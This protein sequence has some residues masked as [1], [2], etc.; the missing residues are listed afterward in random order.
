MRTLVLKTLFALLPLVAACDA[1]APVDAPTPAPGHRAAA[2]SDAPVSVIDTGHWSRTVACS[3]FCVNEYNFWVDLR[4]RND[5]FDKEVGILWTDSGW[6]SIKTSMAHY[7]GPLED[8]WEQ[9]G[10]DVTVGTMA[11]YQSPH[12][13]ELAAFARMAGAAYWDPGNNYYIYNKVDANQPVRRLSSEVHMEA[14]KGVV[15]TG[16][17]RVLDLA[18][19]KKVVVRYSTDG[20]TTWNEVEGYWIKDDDWGFTAENVAAEPLPAEVLYAVRYEVLGQEY[21]DNNGGSDFRHTLAPVFSQNY[22]F[23]DLQKPIS[24]VLNIGGSYR[25]DLPLGAARA[26]VD[27]RDWVDG[28]NVTFSTAELGDGAHT[29]E[30]R[31]RIEGGGEVS[32]TIPF[33]VANQVTP[34][35]RWTPAGPQGVAIG[36]A[37]AAAV[38]GAGQI[39]IAPGNS[40]SSNAAV[41]RYPTWG[42]DAPVAYAALPNGGRAQS[43][44]VD[45]AGR[46]YAVVA[47]SNKAIARFT[48]AGALDA[49][50]GTG[51]VASLEGA[52]MGQ[53]ICY[54]GAVA[55]NTHHVYVTDTCNQRVVRLTLAGV[56][57]GSIGMPDNGYPIPAGLFVDEDGLWVLRSH[58]I[59]RIA[60][61]ADTAMSVAHVIDLE[62]TLNGPKSFVHNPDDGT[63]WVGEG[64]AG[65][66]VVH[67]SGA[68]LGAWYGGSGTYDL[69]GAFSLPQ[70]VVRFPNGDVAVL[71]A[72]GPRMVRFDGALAN[73]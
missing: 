8:G 45:E 9:W 7:E 60:D 51:G 67:E 4:V 24:G 47:Y 38:D 12:E 70:D 16:R 33:T 11:S 39:Y 57:D 28:P 14:G 1:V 43:L 13:I 41:L 63:F 34:L 27:A 56:P 25:T 26:R 6:A 65:V 3:G 66:A 2:L 31:V 30:V 19:D 54:A 62:P 40:W 49:T 44:T 5:A 55:V 48:T 58:Q 23:F 71:G 53:P 52:I 29:V 36:D 21:W 42:S 22:Y 10:V 46:V 50:F 32:N 72:E 59:F 61:S 68:R 15:M 18:F 64:V 20:W 69:A 35:A 17:V 73:P 37:W